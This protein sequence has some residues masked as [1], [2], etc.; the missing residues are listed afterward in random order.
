MAGSEKKEDRD[1]KDC[2]N[3]LLISLKCH[4]HDE[5]KATDNKILEET[6]DHMCAVMSLPL[7]SPTCSE[8]GKHELY[9]NELEIEAKFE[10][11]FAR[12]SET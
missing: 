3:E 5:T 1:S 11:V 12:L 9:P 7:P 10:L 8:C 6:I 4:A 2:D